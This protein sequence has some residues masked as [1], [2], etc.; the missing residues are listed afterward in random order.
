[1]RHIKSTIEVEVSIVIGLQL[2]IFWV[3]RIVVVVGGGGVPWSKNC[4]GG[5]DNIV[6]FSFRNARITPTKQNGFKAVLNIY[7]T[8]SVGRVLLLLL[9]G[10][11]IWYFFN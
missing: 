9:G 1:M 7:I 11:I 4:V 6:G 5:F 8:L 2:I 10:V 3:G